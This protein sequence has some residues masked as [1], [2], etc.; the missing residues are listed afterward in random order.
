MRQRVDDCSIGI[1]LNRKDGFPRSC[2]SREGPFYAIPI[3]V[4][5]INPYLRLAFHA[6]LAI[7]YAFDPISRRV[8]LEGN[9]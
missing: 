2:S 4:A 6:G 7:Y 9:S 1:F 5:Y 8:V 3:G